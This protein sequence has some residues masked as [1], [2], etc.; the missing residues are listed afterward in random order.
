MERETFIK[1][2]SSHGLELS[3][4][5]LQQLDD[6]A[7]FL[8]EYNEKINLTAITEYEEVLEKHFYDSLLL[9]F[10]KEMKG[11]LCDIG[12]GA[13]F[14]GVVLKICYPE[15]KVDLV[16]PLGKRCVFLNEL[17]KREGLEGIDV[18]NVR[19]EDLSRQ[20]REKYDFV[21]ARAVSSLNVLIE[22]CGAL[23]KKD[24]YFIALRGKNGLE[25][26]KGAQRAFMEMGFKEEET[27]EEHLADDSL[28]I[29]SFY[30]KKEV[31]R[32]KFPRKYS[33]IKQKPL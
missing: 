11:S 19:G 26:L 20:A 18:L 14:P 8:K 17:I 24:G 31:T 22:V 5:Q 29:I 28:R 13:G 27:F 12:S 23:V 10:H 3:P 25:E 33:I 6:Y 1:L 30:K 21:T 4:L 9:S 2:L 7:S 16:E 32:G 15:L